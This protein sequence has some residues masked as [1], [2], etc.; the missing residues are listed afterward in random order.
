MMRD[1]PS[2]GFG[3]RDD[4]SSP[5]L[6]WAA[7]HDHGKLQV[8]RR[9]DF[10]IGRGASGILGNKNIDAVVAQQSRFARAVE[11]ATGRD[12]INLRRKARAFGRL[13]AADQVGVLRRCGKCREALAADAEEHAA[14]VWA[15]SPSGGLGIGN[16]G[17]AVASGGFPFRTN[18]GANGKAEAGCCGL[19]IGGDARCE[20]MRR[21]DYGLRLVVLEP[22]Y[23]P[24][25]AAEAADSGFD[26]A[27]GRV[28]RAA[29]EGQGRM[30]PSVTRDAADKLGC[31]RR[32]SEDQDAH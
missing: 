15:E 28:C 5:C 1:Q 23:E 26:A 14:W 8:A 3:G 7:D 11:R 27:R 16:T 2:M 12:E 18:D 31:F 10:R 17:P 20:G 24:V 25:H 19:S 22:G 21:I 13:D 29:G 6:M 32:A 9:F 4:G 30:K